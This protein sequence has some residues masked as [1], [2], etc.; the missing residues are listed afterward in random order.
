MLPEAAKRFEFVAFVQKKESSDSP[1]LSREKI[2]SIKGNGE[3]EACFQEWA[4]DVLCNHLN[5]EN[6]AYAKPPRR[7]YRVCNHNSN[8]RRLILFRR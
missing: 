2:P 5:E 6:D 4:D 7:I 8:M 1:P 3:I